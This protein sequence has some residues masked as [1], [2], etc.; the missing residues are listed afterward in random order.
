MNKMT[1]EALLP[2][3]AT[4]DSWPVSSFS[5]LGDEDPHSELTKLFCHLFDAIMTTLRWTYD[6]ETVLKAPRPSAIGVER[7]APGPCRGCLSL[8]DPPRVTGCPFTAPGAG[9]QPMVIEVFR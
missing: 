5:T 8:R 4:A 2:V 7:A 9:V 3:P 6:E 1:W